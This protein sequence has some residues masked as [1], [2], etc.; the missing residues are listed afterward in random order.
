[1][2]RSWTKPRQIVLIEELPK[3][4]IDRILRRALRNLA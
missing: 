4:N 3:S 1:M 2:N